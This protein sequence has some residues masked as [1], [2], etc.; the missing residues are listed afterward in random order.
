[1]SRY[2]HFGT[3]TRT[4]RTRRECA[5]DE[6]HTRVRLSMD[7]PADVREWAVHNLRALQSGI[8]ARLIGKMC[9]DDIPRLLYTSDAAAEEQS[10]GFSGRGIR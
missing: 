2:S 3:T 7:V 10:G 6:L 9:A 5:S 4:P 8:H 1:M